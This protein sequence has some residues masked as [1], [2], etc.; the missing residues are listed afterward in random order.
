M[1]CLK[2]KMTVTLDKHLLLSLMVYTIMVSIMIITLGSVQCIT[3]IIDINNSTSV[4]REID[5][6]GPNFHVC[7]ITWKSKNYYASECI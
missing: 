7:N 4:Y 2:M 1:T 6:N 3:G 5:D